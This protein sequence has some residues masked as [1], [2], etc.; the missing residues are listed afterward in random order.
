MPAAAT[1]A[2]E[3][4][5]ENAPLHQVLRVSP[6]GEVLLYSGGAPGTALRTPN[7]PV[8]DAAGRLYVSDSGAWGQDDG[9]LFRVD[10]GGETQV[11]ATVPCHFPNGLA[12]APDG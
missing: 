5:R 1:T 12:L 2:A 8:F 9:L 7:Y 6:A 3:G 11:V 10:P 4:P